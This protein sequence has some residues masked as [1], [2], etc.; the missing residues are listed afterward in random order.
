M[1]S[2][3]LW[4]CRF[5]FRFSFFALLAFC[6]LFAGF[7]GGAFLWL[8]MAFHEAA[9]FAVLCW[10]HAKPKALAFSA[11]G[12]RMTADPEKALGFWQS[13]L[14]S[15]AGPAANLLSFAAFHLAGGGNCAYASF[16]LALG[17]FHILPVEPLD[18]G[19]ALR[20]FLN[21]LTDGD[22]A[23]RISFRLS[24]LFLLPL[25]VLGFLVLLRTRYNFSLLA[26]SVYLM[27][28]LVLGRDFFD[29]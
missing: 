20:A 10:F 11:L 27:L 26:L 8:A 25:A 29:G 12:C 23:A 18:G 22:R 13:A 1:L 17:V 9:H 6:C 4:G 28:Y 14:V 24:L 21:C 15:L 16:S 3:S 5:E 7:S 19:L 2:V